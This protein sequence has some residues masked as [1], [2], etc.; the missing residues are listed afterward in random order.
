MIN[1][2]LPYIRHEWKNSNKN[3]KFNHCQT[4]KKNSKNP[5]CDILYLN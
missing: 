2:E 1:I 3:I 4:K 5:N